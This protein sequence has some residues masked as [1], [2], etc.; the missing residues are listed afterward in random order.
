LSF[1]E[2]FDDAEFVLLDDIFEDA[3]VALQKLVGVKIE[4]LKVKEN[5]FLHTL[6]MEFFNQK[7]LGYCVKKKYAK[8]IEVC[9]EIVVKL[10]LKFWYF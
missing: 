5:K 1:D 4:L 2:F 8:S 10:L 6:F 3:F 7:L 9:N